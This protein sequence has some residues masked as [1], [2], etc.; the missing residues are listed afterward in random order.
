MKPTVTTLLV[1]WTA[2]TLTVSWAQDAAPN[3]GPKILV[4]VHQPA[5]SQLR[6]GGN[7]TS[8]Y[9]RRTQYQRQRDVEQTLDRLAVEHRLVR[10]TGW[11]MRSLGVY[12]EVYEAT[13]AGV[14]DQLL[15]QLR[16]DP[17]VDSAQLMQ[18]FATQSPGQLPV[19]SSA[20]LSAHEPSIRY[21][22]PYY[23][24]QHGLQQMD[25]ERS[26][27]VA[28]GAGVKVAIVDSG[29]ERGHPEL[30]A[31]MISENFTDRADGRA[32]F[33][34]TGLAGVIAAKPNN[35]LGIVGVSPGAKI[36]GLRACWGDSEANVTAEC[37]TYSLARALDRAVSMRV[38]VINLSL[39][40]PSDALLAR[41]L[42]RAFEQGIFVVA[43]SRAGAFNFPASLP[44]VLGVDSDSQ[45]SEPG[46]VFAPGQEV[47]TTLPGG[48]YGYLSG[49]SL[50]SAHVAGV[51]ALLVQLQSDLD[52]SELM[53][54][55]QRHPQVNACRLA[56]ELNPSLGCQRNR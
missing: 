48:S 19:R 52:A 34:G 6:R 26:H 42:E 29:I 46:N 16:A 54:L 35:A 5:T 27:V 53:A 22:D 47:M 32:G 41:V 39:A 31:M 56:A 30:E 2:L 12:C 21:N 38:D 28:T 40:G 14:V 11:L 37:N 15:T 23:G 1:F 51:A 36:V 3:E 49:S 25:V 4:T 45:L 43:A 13:Q 24:L 7:P 10:T 55:F 18:S 9:A 17:N 20:Q 33:H 50:A 8:R 44:F